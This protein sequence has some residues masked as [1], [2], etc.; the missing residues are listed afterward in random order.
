MGGVSNGRLHR[1]GGNEKQRTIP[2]MPKLTAL[3]QDMD[4]AEARRLQV[5]GERIINEIRAFRH[6]QMRRREG[7]MA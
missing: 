3:G 1:N 5:W 7:V 4:P 2:T 6:R